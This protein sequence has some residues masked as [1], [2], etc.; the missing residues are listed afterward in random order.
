MS[1]HTR[2]MFVDLDVTFAMSPLDV[3]ATAGQSLA[4]PCRSPD[5][6]P[7]ARLLWYRDDAPFVERPEGQFAAYMNSSGSLVFVSV[8]LSDE[9]Q[10]LCVAEN[11]HSIPMA[12]NSNPA[13]LTVQGA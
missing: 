13:V 9:G 12:R 1:N 7:P 10:Y 6:Y 3:T 2:A 11:S 4:L 8:Q 5:S